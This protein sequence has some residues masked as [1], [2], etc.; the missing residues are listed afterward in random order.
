MTHIPNLNS[1]VAVVAGARHGPGRDIVLALG[2]SGATVYNVGVQGER[3]PISFRG[4][5]ETLPAVAAII[6]ILIK[7][8]HPVKRWKPLQTLGLRGIARRE[9]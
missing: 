2:E 6:Y 7:P 9:M 3:R 5:D 8:S 1:K 4:W